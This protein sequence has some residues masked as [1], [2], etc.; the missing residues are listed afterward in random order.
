[1]DVTRGLLYVAVRYP[2][3]VVFTGARSGSGMSLVRIGFVNIM[4]GIM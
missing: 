4:I 2:H 3:I 1:M